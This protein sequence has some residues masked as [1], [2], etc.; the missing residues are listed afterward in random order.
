MRAR[1]YRT[2]SCSS[3]YASATAEAQAFAAASQWET[4]PKRIRAGIIYRH[5]H[6]V[7]WLWGDWLTDCEYKYM[8]AAAATIAHW[9]KLMRVITIAFK[10]PF[11]KSW[12]SYLGPRQTRPCNLRTAPQFKG[13]VFTCQ[14]QIT[15]AKEVTTMKMMWC[16]RWKNF[17]LHVSLFVRQVASFPTCFLIVM[18]SGA[19]YDIKL[20]LGYWLIWLWSFWTWVSSDLIIRQTYL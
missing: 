19:R 17:Q 14:T 13:Q 18:A 20:F 2:E 15:R 1:V 12:T 16:V 4:D 7:V 11:R 10:Q 6:S 9:R 3:T 8:L 5:C